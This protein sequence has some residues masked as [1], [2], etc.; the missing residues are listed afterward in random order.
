MRKVLSIDKNWKFIVEPQKDEKE[1]L[2]HTETYASVKAG[3]SR[4][5]ASKFANDGDW[6]SVN[7]PHDRKTEVEI[8][9][10]ENS[11]HGGR[12]CETIWYRKNFE[13]PE[14][15]SDKSFTLVFEGI[16][17][18]S[19]IFFNGSLMKVGE[20]AYN[21]QVIDISPRVH[22]GGEPNVIAV[23]IDGSKCEG[24]WYEGSGIYRHA[25]LYI[26][27]KLH[28]AHN[29]LFACPVKDSDGNWKVEVSAEVENSAYIPDECV[30]EFVI[31]D[32]NGN[33]V[34]K[35]S[36]NATVDAIQTVTVKTEITVDNP[37]L[38]DI[39]NP[40][41][42]KV[43]CRLKKKDETVDELT[44]NFGFRTAVFDAE[45]GFVLNG[46]QVKLKG[47]CCHQDHAGV[48]VAVPDSIHEYR[49]IRLKEMGANAYRCAH[50]WPA[51]EILDACDRLGMV[52]MDENRRFEPS[53]NKILEF[54]NMI[55]RDRNHPSIIMWSLFNEEELQGSD[56]GRRIYERLKASVHKLDKSRA[57][58]G[59]LHFGWL[60][61]TGTALSMDVT[62]INYN[63]GMLDR[64]HAKYP[65]QPIVGSENNSS[66][67]IRGEVYD[68][69]DNNILKDYD[70]CATGWGSSMQKA[71]SV[72]R[73]RDFVSGLFIWTGFDYRGEPTPFEY[74]TVS[75][76]F[77]VM[78][79]C[80]FPKTLYYICQACFKE[81]PVMHIFPHWNHKAGEVVKVI[82][83][84]NGDEV[85][86]F[87]NGKSL[88]RKESEICNQLIWDVEYVPGELKAVSYKNGGVFAEEVV[89]TSGIPAKIVAEAH[90]TTV[91]NNGL[92]AVAVNVFVADADGNPVATANNLIKF[93]AK[94]GKILG[95]GNG[96]PN[97]HET[98]ASNERLLF[99][100]KCQAV[101]LCE[102]EAK[103]FKVLVTSE[104]LEGAEISFE[105]AEESAPETVKSS[106]SRNIYIWTKSVKGF[107][108]KPAGDMKIH[109]TDMNDFV[110]VNVYGTPW[111]TLEDGW[112][113]YR[114]KVEVSGEGRVMCNMFITEFIYDEYEMW[115][116]GRLVSAEVN[117]EPRMV[118][119]VP[120]PHTLDV[121]FECE[122]GGTAEITILI[123]VNG[124]SRAGI[125]GNNGKRIAFVVK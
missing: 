40:T 63:L 83:V 97:S 16:S 48:G 91:K 77:G 36:A 44:E 55:R 99:N 95:C 106:G 41:L 124:L 31:L 76:L 125:P 119:D 102:Q 42:Y 62:G 50:N 78:D 1:K 8:S 39:D 27:E 45:K 66:L 57:V 117:K 24:W 70:D 85:E 74:P 80:G 54:E 34:G 68:D 96:N 14:E 25:K 113:L 6:R 20:S 107:A 92:D 49:I 93:E 13:I 21:E 52:V 56:E 69:R 90:K 18:Y 46:K 19:E 112:N 60:E 61:D 28:I 82:T 22:F 105:I 115:V 120:C 104:G 110:P 103:E 43:V 111:Q 35:S 32:K 123:K 116:N 88:G 9:P 94:G 108:E 64:F 7:L 51:K 30:A 29:G 37:E 114:T 72:V 23:K 100:G 33:A 101:V 122:A 65:N 86:L 59:A 89:K 15:F 71:W 73:E 5:F 38:W 58:T 26:K 12:V 17:P 4:G 98:D 10:D 79:T 67:T 75:S 47:V 121:D 118:A 3:A 53:E 84:T 109:D 81:E 2:G 87:L 11:V